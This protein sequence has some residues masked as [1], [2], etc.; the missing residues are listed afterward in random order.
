MSI[1]AILFFFV[2][3]RLEYVNLMEKLLYTVIK[4]DC[5]PR[6]RVRTNETLQERK[7]IQIEVLWF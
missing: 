7:K 4:F 5:Q 3:T 2:Q 6:K 1:A